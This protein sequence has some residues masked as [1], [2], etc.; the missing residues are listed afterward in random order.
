MA[1]TAAA[2]EDK[3]RITSNL[4]HCGLFCYVYDTHSLPIFYLVAFHGIF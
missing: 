1:E 2:E 4:R 3:Q